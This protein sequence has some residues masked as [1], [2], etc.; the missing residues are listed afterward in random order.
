MLLGA[1]GAGATREQGNQQ[2]NVTQ[3]IAPIEWDPVVIN[4]AYS[5]Q[6]TQTI[7]D[8]LYEYEPQTLNPEPKIAADEP[9]VERDGERYIVELREEPEFHNGDPV[10]AEDAVHTFLAPV[11]TEYGT[12]EHFAACH[13]HRDPGGVSSA[14][15]E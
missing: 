15:R 1:G 11:E 3:Q 13:L 4:D 7:Y 9:E 2:L 10:T 8:G 5:T 6:I 12:D 14:A